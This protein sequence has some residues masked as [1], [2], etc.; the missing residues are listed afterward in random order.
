MASRARAL[1]YYAEGRPPSAS[2]WKI[3]REFLTY[4]EEPHSLVSM[5]TEDAAVKLV[6]AKDKR[7][8][9]LGQDGVSR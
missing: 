7:L 9:K 6:E 3:A 5:A 2:R 4:M 8:K 1:A